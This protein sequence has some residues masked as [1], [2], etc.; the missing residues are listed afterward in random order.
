[1][2]N[3]RRND[4]CRAENIL[5][6]VVSD[7]SILHYARAR[8]KYAICCS[9]CALLIYFYLYTYVVY[10]DKFENFVNKL[11]QK[12]IANDRL[13]LEVLVNFIPKFILIKVKFDVIGENFRLQMYKC[14]WKIRKIPS[15]KLM[16][17]KI[18]TSYSS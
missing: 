3:K 4:A 10:A 17:G 13:T 11:R 7:F 14:V 16:R 2:H 8:R 9:E 12:L 6:G 18:R 5:V 1:M 15:R